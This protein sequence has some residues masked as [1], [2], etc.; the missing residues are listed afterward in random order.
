[1]KGIL[2][3]TTGEIREAEFASA[4]AVAEKA[5]GAPQRVP[6]LDDYI[7]VCEYNAKRPVNR[8]ASHILGAVI[9]GDAVIVRNAS[10]APS[11]RM[12]SLDDLDVQQLAL[13]LDDVQQDLEKKEAG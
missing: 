2:V 7:M 1:M 11:V 3:K 10:R 5:G 8:T 12:T 4:R 13:I 9:Y 6:I